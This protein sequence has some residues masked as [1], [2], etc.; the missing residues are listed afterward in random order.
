MRHDYEINFNKN[1]A[2]IQPLKDQAEIPR[3]SFNLR[4]IHS[5]GEMFKQC[6]IDI[7]CVVL[8][9]DEKEQNPNGPNG[10]PRRAMTVADETETSI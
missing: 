8:E 2:K 9:I 7:A 1:E 3:Y 6:T 4:T 10:R 5:I